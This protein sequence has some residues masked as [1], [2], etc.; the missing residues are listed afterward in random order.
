MSPSRRS[1]RH[2]RTTSIT[3]LIYA[4]RGLP[5]RAGPRKPPLLEP[6]ERDCPKDIPHVLREHVFLARQSYQKASRVTVGTL[7]VAK[8]K[9]KRRANLSLFDPWAIFSGS[10]VLT[11]NV[12]WRLASRKPRLSNRFHALGPPR[13]SNRDTPSRHSGRAC[14][15]YRRTVLRHRARLFTAFGSSSI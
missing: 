7:I 3:T 12:L 6:D 13:R 9:H 4:M 15:V 14:V 1:L 10:M 8:C 11:A 5:V 2:C